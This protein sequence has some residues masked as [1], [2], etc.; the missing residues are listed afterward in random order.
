MFNSIASVT[1]NIVSKG[2]EA[3]IQKA[4]NFTTDK[5]NNNKVTTGIL[6]PIQNFDQN[7]N[8]NGYHAP[9]EETGMMP[10][11]TAYTQLRQ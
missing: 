11:S 9:Q 8:F 3:P 10:Y 7:I 6:N 4:V 1:N 5:L 2:W